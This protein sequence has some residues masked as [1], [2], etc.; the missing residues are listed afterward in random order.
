MHIQR[1]I[2]FLCLKIHRYIRENYCSEY[3]EIKLYQ[4]NKH[5][6]MQNFKYQFYKIFNN[7]A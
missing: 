5:K 6:N 2:V 1:L 4:Q 7:R 3:E